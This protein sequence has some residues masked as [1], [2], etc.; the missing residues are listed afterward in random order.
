MLLD[1]LM[2]FKDGT[3]RAASESQSQGKLQNAWIV[4]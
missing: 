3:L 2:Q 1:C 4:G